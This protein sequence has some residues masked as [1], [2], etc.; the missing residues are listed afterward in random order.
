M[1]YD[2]SALFFFHSSIPLTI[3]LKQFIPDLE[4]RNGNGDRKKKETL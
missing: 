2:W 3:T 4:R 1:F